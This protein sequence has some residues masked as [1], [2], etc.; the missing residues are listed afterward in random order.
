MLKRKFL[1]IIILMIG[2]IVLF[3]CEYE[4]ITIDTPDP[5][6]PVSYSGEIQPIF[7]DYCAGCHAV[8]STPPDLTSANSYN[9]LFSGNY[10]DT[11][12]PEQSVI[13]TCMMPP[14]G[15]MSQ[16]S[17]AD[18]AGLVLNWIIQGAKNN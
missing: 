11:L 14:N 8:G 6:I 9:A 7:D 16:Y 2:V 12:A 5:T 10:V 13:Y 3:S 1:H 17:S 15:S 18:K 4:K